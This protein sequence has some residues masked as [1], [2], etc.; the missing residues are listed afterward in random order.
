MVAVRTML[1]DD[2]Y[3]NR[4]IDK[5]LRDNFSYLQ[6]KICIL[7]KQKKILINNEPKKFN[8]RLQ[9][10]D[11]ID[12][13]DDLF[14]KNVDEHFRLRKKNVVDGKLEYENNGFSWKNKNDNCDKNDAINYK[15]SRFGDEDCFI[16]NKKSNKLHKK[17]LPIE[18]I[19]KIKQSILFENEDVIILNKPYGLSVQ[20]GT[21]VKYSLEDFFHL[22]SD[23]KLRIVHRIDKDTRGLLILAKNVPVAVKLTE[24][25]RKRQVH[26][27]YIAVLSGIPLKNSGTI[28]TYI[29]LSNKDNLAFNARTSE[30]RMNGKEAITKYK[31]LKT[32]EEKNISLVEF[33]PLTGRKHQIRLHSQH[34]KCPIVG[35]EKYG[36]GKQKNKKLQLFAVYIDASP[37][38]KYELNENDLQN[39]IDF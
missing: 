9:K 1:V 21:G 4:R 18:M 29:V 2:D 26:K 10:G 27:K 36:F 19:Y 11:V 7:A 23:K 15:K 38:V 24:M 34:I 39:M 35:D 17:D 32:D 28:K 3:I 30:E 31:V 8:Y 25:F 16:S 20:G 13:L 14:K 12:V 37:I 5:Y 33:Y 22:L 6:G